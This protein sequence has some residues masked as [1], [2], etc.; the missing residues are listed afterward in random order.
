[1]FYFLPP[2]IVIASP[3]GIAS[4]TPQ[5]THIQSGKHIALTS[6]EH[7][8]IG[9]AKSL[10]AA[11]GE[12]IRLFA[13]KAGFRLIA[14]GGDIDVKALKDSINL[15]AKLNITQ[16]AD[17]ITI[18]AKKELKLNGG[19]SYIHLN[20]S[21]IEGGTPGKF[22]MHTSM[23]SFPSPASE[24][25][26][27]PTTQPQKGNLDLIG[28]YVKGGPLKQLEYKVI[29]ANGGVH[30]GVLDDA[31]KKTLSGIPAGLTKIHFGDDNR[32]PWNMDSY[33]GKET[34]KGA[35]AGTLSG[36][37]GGAAALSASA[38]LL[39]SVGDLL[40]KSG[41]PA[42]AV[43]SRAGNAQQ[44]LSMAKSAQQLLQTG[45]ALTMG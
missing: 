44:A 33:I 6:G 11:A 27:F 39:S 2:H 16:T 7:T 3:A 23:A 36:Q 37:N 4:T 25:A 8:S 29:D 38:E 31:G 45:R 12:A 14:A 20:S 1:M 22:T 10:L 24:A 19:T 35:E 43:L 5:T 42:A 41:S 34:I 30:Q 13:M 18:S 32:D 9:A 28:A 21:A 40:G 17:T 26:A 15:L